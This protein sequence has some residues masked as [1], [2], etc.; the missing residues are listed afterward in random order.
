MTDMKSCVEISTTR[1]ERV[2]TLHIVSGAP[3]G[4]LFDAS[5]EIHE[6]VSELVREG[7]KN[8]LQA[9][10]ASESDS[11]QPEETAGK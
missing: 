6:K 5:H 7:I 3:W 9:K 8:S 10:A 1:G 2:Y 11:S 4:E